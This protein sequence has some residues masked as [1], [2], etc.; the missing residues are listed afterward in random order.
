MWWRCWRALATWGWSS[1]PFECWLAG[2]GL[3]T[4]EL[5]AGFRGRPLANVEADP[6]M[7]ALAEDADPPEELEEMLDV[8]R[9]LGR[10][11]ETASK[12]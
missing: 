12:I 7:E 11:P 6:V 9:E 1:S 3:G 2:R 10:A 8:L 4:L 5:A